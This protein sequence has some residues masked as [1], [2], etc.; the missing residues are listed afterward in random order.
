MRWLDLEPLTK[1][2]ARPRKNR[3]AAIDR[4]WRA[5]SK[6]ASKPETFFQGR[7]Q[8]DDLASF[9]NQQLNDLEPTLS[10]YLGPADSG[11]RGHRLTLTPEGNHQLRPFVHAIMARAPRLRG[12]TFGDRRP[13]LPVEI[14]QQKFEQLLGRPSLL[15]RVSVHARTDFA[16]DLCFERPSAL[17]E[18]EADEEANSLASDLLGEEH[19]YV[20]LAQVE[21]SK[22][23]SKLSVELERLP[24][25]FEKM[26]AQQRR[27][28]PSQLKRRWRDVN[29]AAVINLE[30]SEHDDSARADLMT[31]STLDLPLWQAMRQPDFFSRRYSRAGEVFAF[32]KIDG[33]VGLKGSRYQDRGDIEEALDEELIPKGLGQVWGGG[34]GHRY[35]YVDLALTDLVH[36]TRRIKQVFA[37]DRLPAPAW[38]FFCDVDLVQEWVAVG[39]S[40]DPPP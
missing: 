3:E 13:P 2:E 16:L 26:L 38:L 34:T 6:R 39:K 12:W 18:A 17:S 22:R 28:L 8:G 14:A 35:S 19:F 24:K 32:L 4:W 36:G 33:S 9:I 5:F 7:R 1:S 27:K 15:K 25:T 23:K 11:R 37:R 21:T 10:W 30:P 40:N 20:H 31:A 29:N